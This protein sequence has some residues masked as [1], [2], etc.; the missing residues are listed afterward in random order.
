MLSSI[1]RK[2]SDV[3]KNGPKGIPIAF[4]WNWLK[5]AHFEHLDISQPIQVQ[6]SI[7]S[8]VHVQDEPLHLTE[9]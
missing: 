7:W 6:C 3:L 5:L 4:L 9:L 8:L 1:S 2:Y